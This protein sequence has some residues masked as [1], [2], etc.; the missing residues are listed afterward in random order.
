MTDQELIADLQRATTGFRQLADWPSF[1]AGL[2]LA[3]D[4]ARLVMDTDPKLDGWADQVY[5]SVVS[6]PANV[7]EA[8]GR[9]SPAQLV[10]YLRVGRGSAYET[11]ALLLAAPVPHD[12]TDRCRE[13]VT[14]IDRDFAKA[15]EGR[16]SDQFAWTASAK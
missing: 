16:L 10:Q 1:A 7:A 4:V 13:L 14:L 8:V 2:T 11:L 3:K 12:L 6:V 9:G 5:R 15:V